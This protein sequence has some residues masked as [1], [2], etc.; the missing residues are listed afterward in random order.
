[1]DNNFFS[2]ELKASGPPESTNIEQNIMKNISE[3][4]VNAMLLF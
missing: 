4:N 1:M 2:E 3:T